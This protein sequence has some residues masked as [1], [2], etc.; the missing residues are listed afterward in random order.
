[1]LTP[2]NNV[3]SHPALTIEHELEVPKPDAD[4]VAVAPLWTLQ[5]S[6]SNPN[7]QQFIQMLITLA[8]QTAP[9][10]LPL[11]LGT[12]AQPDKSS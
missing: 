8:V 10:W 1:M 12:P 3:F 11:V 9:I 7:V 4:G 6:S 2:Y 5:M